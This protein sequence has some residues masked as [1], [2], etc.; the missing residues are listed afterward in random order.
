MH[1]LAVYIFHLSSN[2]L[3]GGVFS[4]APLQRLKAHLSLGLVR[5]A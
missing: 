5:D 1:G 2:F 3:V 4:A